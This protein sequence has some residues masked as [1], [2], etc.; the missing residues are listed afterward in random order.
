MVKSKM[1]L[2]LLVGGAALQL[3]LGGCDPEVR[4]AV[5]TGFATS[6]TSLASAIIEAFFLSLQDAGSSTSQPVVQ[7]VFDTLRSMT[8]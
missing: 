1:L 7:A 6:L 2:P 3:N 4:D 8:A 5:L